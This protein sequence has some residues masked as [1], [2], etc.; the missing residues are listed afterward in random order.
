[1]TFFFVLRCRFRGDRAPLPPRMFPDRCFLCLLLTSLLGVCNPCVF[2]FFSTC[3]PVIS[4]HSDGPLVGVCNTFFLLRPVWPPFQILVQGCTRRRS[5]A[6]FT[7][8]PH[9][10]HCLLRLLLGNSSPFCPDMSAVFSCFQPLPIM[11]GVLSGVV[12]TWGTGVMG[13]PC[14]VSLLSIALDVENLIFGSFLLWPFSL[15][16]RRPTAN[17]WLFAL[18]AVPSGKAGALPSLPSSSF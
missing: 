17:G 14:I 11:A 8:K 10:L 7:G 1:M 18:G 16:L 2:C 3:L 4:L 6:V 5:G 15:F 9:F 12:Y 13:L